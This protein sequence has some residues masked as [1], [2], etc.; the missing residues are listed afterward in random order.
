MLLLQILL[1]DNRTGESS[2]KG[3]YIYDD[4]RKA[5]QD[6]DLIKYI[7]KARNMGG[8]T[9]DPKLMKLSDSDIVEIILFPVVNEACRVLD[10]GISLKASD[11]DVASIM[12]MGFPSY[13]GG[14]MFWAD[15]LSAKYVYDRLEAW[16][17]DYGQFF[18]PCEYLAARA[19]QGASLA[20][21]VDGAKSRL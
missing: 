19:R 11:L 1:E 21:K 12:G 10:E 2:R 4:K 14:V 18:K 8:V 5:S 7:E 17:K 15:S 16:S 13:R 6:P 20:A 3:F 9:Q